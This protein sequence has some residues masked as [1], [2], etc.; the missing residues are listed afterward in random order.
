MC[1]SVNVY[2]TKA[3]LFFFPSCV[4][5]RPKPKTSFPVLILTQKIFIYVIT[6]AA[7]AAAVAIA[8]GDAKR[9]MCALEPPSV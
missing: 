1:L 2:K 6:V 4:K 7:A 3:R 5:S 8:P 9:T